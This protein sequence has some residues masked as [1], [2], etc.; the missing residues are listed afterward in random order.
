M[1]DFSV[2]NQADRISRIRAWAEIL[3]RGDPADAPIVRKMEAL[4]QKTGHWK[5]YQK[6]TYAATIADR[7]RA[8]LRIVPEWGPHGRE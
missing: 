5:A 1:L 3:T 7:G 6:E 8:A 4:I 2:Q